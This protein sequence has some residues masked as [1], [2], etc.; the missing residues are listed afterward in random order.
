MSTLMTVARQL[1]SSA[2]SVAAVGLR[3]GLSVATNVTLGARRV[4]WPD[5]PGPSTDGDPAPESTAPP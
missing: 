2:T 3:T 1:T 5:S 4:V